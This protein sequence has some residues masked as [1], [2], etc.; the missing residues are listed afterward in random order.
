MVHERGL[1]HR[2]FSVV[3]WREAP[4][5]PEILMQ[6]R[7]F[8]KYH[9]GG[10]WT[11]SCCSHP[12]VGEQLGDAVLRRLEEE[13]GAD[14]SAMASSPVEVGSFVYRA[15]FAH[16]IAEFEYDHVFVAKYAGT[17]TPDPEE[18]AE[19]AWLDAASVMQ[20]VMAR[21]ERYTAWLPGVLALALGQIHMPSAS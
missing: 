9:S 16:G 5:G 20:D 21:P 2:A 12:R 14:L 8:G 18:I 15:T 3:L 19:T 6:R 13:L 11:N 4:Q 1:L 17:L 7:A 10:L